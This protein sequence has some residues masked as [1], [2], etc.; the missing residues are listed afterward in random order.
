MG[1]SNSLNKLR[2]LFDEVQLYVQIAEENNSNDPLRVLLPVG[3]RYL[4]QKDMG[5]PET[6]AL[7]SFGSF[8]GSKYPELQPYLQ[9]E[10]VVEAQQQMYSALEGVLNETNT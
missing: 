2:T 3:Y 7:I 5:I 9:S 10:R 6:Q 4:M 8:L 1:L